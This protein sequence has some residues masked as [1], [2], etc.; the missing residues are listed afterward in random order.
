LAGN[1]AIK[2]GVSEKGKNLKV[3]ATLYTNQNC[4]ED[5]C[6][7]KKEKRNIAN[8]ASEYSSSGSIKD[9]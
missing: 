6:D 7:G 3:D 9:D 8:P 5:K 1:G 2:S 4:H